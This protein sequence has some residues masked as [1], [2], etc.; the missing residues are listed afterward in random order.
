MTLAALSRLITPGRAVVLVLGVHLIAKVI[1]VFASVPPAQT[2]ADIGFGFGPYVESLVDRGRFEAC[3]SGVCSYASRM[4]LLPLV[5][6]ALALV[7]GKA[8]LPVA[9]AKAVLLSVMLGAAAL[10]AWRRSEPSYGFAA[11]L[12]FVLL[13]PQPLKHAAN[14]HYEEGFLVEMLVAAALLAASAA[15]DRDPDRRATGTLAV[16]LA[17]LFSAA[18]LAKWS[19][20]PLALFGLAFAVQRARG[21]VRVAVVL[22]PAAAF[23][24]W[25]F[26]NWT[27]SGDFRFDSSMNG[28]NFWRGFSAEARAIYPE[29][30]LDRLF[31]SEAIELADGS[32][33]RPPLD[34][35]R[36]APV[37][38]WEHDRYYRSAAMKWLP[39]NLGE[40]TRFTAERIWI[41]LFEIRNFP[42]RI[43]AKRDEKRAVGAVVAAAGVA[44]MLLARLALAALIVRRLAAWRSGR[45][46]PAGR[47]LFL[48]GLV[49]AGLYLAPYVLVFGYERHV[50][51]VI[52][53]SLILLAWSP[54]QA[55]SQRDAD[56]RR[57]LR[58]QSGLRAST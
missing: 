19:I 33:V 20:L 51:P 23:A 5:Y 38:E 45:L 22:I 3:G 2:V 26:H 24:G 31:D 9:A 54:T 15:R 28:E 21:F 17:A 47:A 43:S 52:C 32:S 57:G 35:I 8:L 50:V 34:L 40:Y 42:E 36:S 10:F 48:G 16:A 41:M 4:P 11:L 37:E 55:S 12:A 44:W 58:D 1:F 14:P 46:A 49:A 25:G 7:F 56:A 18:V 29:V 39:A 27:T 6:A 30:S 53:F 13:G